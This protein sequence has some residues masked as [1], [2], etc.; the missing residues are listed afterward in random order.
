MPG[1]PALVDAPDHYQQ[2]L[3]PDPPPVRLGHHARRDQL[4]ELRE[5]ALLKGDP[6]RGAHAFYSGSFREWWEP[7]LERAPVDETASWK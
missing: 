1:R 2:L 5:K 3:R 4:H 6:I 7:L